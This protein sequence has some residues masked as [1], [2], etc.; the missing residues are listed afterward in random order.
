MTRPDLPTATLAAERKIGPTSSGRAILGCGSFGGIGSTL[1][2]LGTGL[3][4][5]E[6]FAVMDTAVALGITI[7]D[8]ADGYAGGRSEE[9]IGSWLARGGT[10]TVSTKVEES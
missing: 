3:D 6:A 8:T 10:A 2:T 7:F 9:I 1:S 4:E 5:Q